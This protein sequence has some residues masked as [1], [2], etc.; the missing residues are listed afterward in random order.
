MSANLPGYET[1][2]SASAKQILLSDHGV[3]RGQ[4]GIIDASTIIANDSFAIQG[5]GNQRHLEP[6]TALKLVDTDVPGVY[7]ATQS[8]D[9][10][11][12]LNEY[13]PLYDSDGNAKDR[14]FGDGIVAGMVDPNKLV[15]TPS[16][17]RNS[18]GLAAIVWGDTAGQV[19]PAATTTT[20]TTTAEPTTTG[21]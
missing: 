14:S 6:G 16:A 20:T 7:R 11:L 4:R 21:E 18:P 12:L 5:S 9:A 19:S 17:I 8:N 10:V 1:G 15:G 3:I 13:V 2:R